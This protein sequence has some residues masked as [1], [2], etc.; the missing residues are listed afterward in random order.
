MLNIRGDDNE[1]QS[2]NERMHIDS[3]SNK[4]KG[5]N[6]VT[7]SLHNITD[8]NEPI[9]ASYMLQYEQLYYHYRLKS[10]KTKY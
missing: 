9:I 5:G 10:N 7:T 4:I 6:S 8:S 2:K 3:V 1:V